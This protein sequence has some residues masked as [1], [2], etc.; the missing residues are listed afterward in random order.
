F[1]VYEPDRECHESTQYSWI[2]GP[3]LVVARAAR[4]VSWL[5]MLRRQRGAE[6]PGP[7]RF[8][9]GS[10]QAGFHWW[11]SGRLGKIMLIACFVT[12]SPTSYC[13]LQQ[14]QLSLL[15]AAVFGLWH[16]YV[17]PYTRPVLSAAG[18]GVLGVA[19]GWRVVVH[20]GLQERHRHVRRPRADPLLVCDGGPLGEGDISFGRRRRSTRVVFAAMGGLRILRPRG[21]SLIRGRPI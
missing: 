16:W 13:P 15:V 8:L 9:T 11:R 5:T 12:L 1:M 7:M 3:A 19:G 17:L 18:H 10:Y 4:P 21:A 6:P 14:L 20:P 2:C